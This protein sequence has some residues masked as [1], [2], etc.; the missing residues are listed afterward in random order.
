MG[1]I[2][3]G[4]SVGVKYFNEKVLSYTGRRCPSSISEL[5]VNVSKNIKTCTKLCT[6][7]LD[8]SFGLACAMGVV[9]LTASSLCAGEDVVNIITTTMLPVTT[10][11]TTNASVVKDN[12]TTEMVFLCF[13][14]T[15]SLILKDSQIYDWTNP[16][17]NPLENIC[18]DPHIEVDCGSILNNTELN[19]TVLKHELMDL[20]ETQASYE[21]YF[22]HVHD[23][24]KSYPAEELYRLCDSNVTMLVKSI[25]CLQ[26]SIF[27]VANQTI[28]KLLKLSNLRQGVCKTNNFGDLVIKENLDIFCFNS[29]LDL[30]YRS[31]HAN[32]V[33]DEYL[34]PLPSVLP[35]TAANLL[36]SSSTDSCN[37]CNT[38]TLVFGVGS[39]AT[40]LATTMKTLYQQHKERRINRSNISCLGL[41]KATAVLVNDGLLI[42]ASGL[43]SS[44]LMNSLLHPCV[45]VDEVTNKMVVASTV[46][47]G[48]SAASKMLGA[49]VCASEKALDE[50][51][52]IELQ[53]LNE[54]ETHIGMDNMAMDF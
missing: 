23:L 14:D 38:A 51:A 1:A 47:Y 27:Y 25:E 30:I 48:A 12:S 31:V 21:H 7:F 28:G 5:R 24:T 40:L 52:I 8:S 6:A 50:E 4:F 45:P 2:G 39:A 17:T 43:G 3:S 22:G 37:T 32:N 35:T 41:R 36:T 9:G 11:A 33:S 54:Y 20:E 44:V 16:L 42:A 13:K 46:L 18:A 15:G 49:L 19:S 26:E 53:E 34:W 29:S 10:L